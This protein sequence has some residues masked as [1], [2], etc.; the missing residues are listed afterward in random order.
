MHDIKFI[1]ENSKLFDDSLKKR[2]LSPQSKKLIKLHDEY[3]QNL[4]QVQILQ[5][6][7]N[8]FSKKFSDKNNK[9]PIN[10]L[11]NSV[12]EIKEKIS[13]L[14]EVTDKKLNELNSILYEI[15][16]M[17]DEITPLG[18]SEEDNKIIQ[19]CKK[20][21]KFDFIPKDHV[22]LAETLGLLDFNT[23]SKL[24][25]SRFS[26]L[27]SDLALMHRALTNLMLDV[28]VG[29]F[30]YVECKVPEL[31]KSHC[32]FGTGQL[33]KFSEDLFQTNFNDLWL[34]PTSE[35]SLTNMNREDLLNLKD[36]PLRYTSYTNCFRSEAGASGKD[37]KG[38][39]REHQ[40]GK[41]ELVSIIEP[42]KSMDEL[43]RM[44][45]CVEAIL[46]KLELP[47]RQ[48]SL[49][50]ADTGFS[51]SYTVDF[52]I[53]MPG[54]N[55]FR[56]VSSCSNCKDF[57]SRRMKMRAKNHET[58]EIFYPHTLNGSSLAVGRIIVSILENY[59][60]KDGTIEIPKSL[61]SYMNNK[62]KLTFDEK[63]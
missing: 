34:I 60:Q 62:K 39:M 41:V 51:A 12:S 59:Q 52:E 61:R 29:L 8:K 17:L 9:I 46:K 20:I 57:Q 24:S 5:E 23:S 33:P 43:H 31:V 25:G 3:L 7:R 27:K 63:N 47:Y 56:E 37:T 50:S 2:K 14:N 44:I 11:K 1:K 35:V 32:L 15:P 42:E 48:V 53:W 4:K 58:G 22:E 49:C 26:V 45:S 13:K 30:D 10:D 21:K 28:N 19:E 55:K 54:Q 36:L 40:F 38:L 16:N 6:N 18:D